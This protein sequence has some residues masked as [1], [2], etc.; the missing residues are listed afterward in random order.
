MGKAE[1][2]GEKWH[3]H[4]TALTVGPDYRRLGLAATLMNFLEEVSEKKNTYF[5]DLF[6]RV[7]NKVAIN[8]YMKLGYIV[9]RTIIDY[10]SGEKEEDA[11][12]KDQ[13]EGAI[14]IHGASCKYSFTFRHAESVFPRQGQ[15]VNDPSEAPG[16]IRGGRVLRGHGASI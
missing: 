7:S 8:M 5:V 3:G 2:N 12:G 10:Y 16:S 1:G 14:K 15:K 11:Y 4:V 9:Y 6:V 13:G